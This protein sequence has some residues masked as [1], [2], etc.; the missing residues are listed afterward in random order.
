VCD[1]TSDEVASSS[2]T[3][4]T[5]TTTAHE[6]LSDFI[7]SYDSEGC[8]CDSSSRNNK[9]AKSAS[10]KRRVVFRNAV[11][12][13]TCPPYEKCLTDAETIQLYHN[14]IWYTVRLSALYVS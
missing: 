3:K 14:D 4:S 13:I 11:D 5:H 9:R 7:S 1:T 12:I 8:D 10:A 2:R 6:L